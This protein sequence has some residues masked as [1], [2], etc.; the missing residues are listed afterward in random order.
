[1]VGLERSDVRKAFKAR[2]ITAA[3]QKSL[4]ELVEWRESGNDESMLASL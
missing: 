3:A 1:M 4:V 2:R